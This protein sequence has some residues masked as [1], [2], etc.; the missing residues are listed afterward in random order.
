MYTENNKIL[1]ERLK[2]TYID[3]EIYTVFVGW[4]I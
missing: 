1:L 2:K 3:E 4:K